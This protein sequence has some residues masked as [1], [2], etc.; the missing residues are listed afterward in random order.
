MSSPTN[1]D[2]LLST[3][4]ESTHI[5]DPPIVEALET[6]SP[7]EEEK[8]GETTEAEQLLSDG[9]ID[10]RVAMLGNVD[11]GKS[12]LISVLAH[13]ALDD[14]RGAA[15]ARVFRHKH[16]QENGRTSSISLELM[17][18]DER[19]EQVF[20]E[21][22]RV[23][24]S[25]IVSRSSKNITLIDL[26][27][28]EKY[29]KTTIFGLTGM[30]PDYCFVIVGANMGVSKMTR[31]HLGIALSLKIP[32]IVIITKIDISPENIKFETFQNLQKLLKSPAA[33]KKMP[34]VVRD[35]DDVSTCAHGLPSGR[36]VPFFEISSVTGENVE[37]LRSF[38]GMLPQRIVYDPNAPAEFVI[39]GSYQVSGIGL[40]IAGTLNKGTVQTNDHLL[41]GPDRTSQFR[42]VA[43]KSI[44]SKRTP[45]SSVTAGQSATFAIRA[46]TK[47][48][49]L[50]RVYIRKGMVLVSESGNPRAVEE[51][52]AE[53]LI[54][55]HHTTIAIGY[56]PMIHCG[57]VRQSAR[58]LS[59]DREVL[60]TGD[61]AIVRFR[62]MYRS[63]YVTEGQ[64][65]IF[66]EG[67]AKGL[68]RIISCSTFH[69]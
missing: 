20:G 14:G 59:M 37:L 38:V 53:V 10:V 42:P 15:R 18:F 61:R 48:D 51:F 62:F 39:D 16:E 35:M 58:I 64:K 44:H 27:G 55:H 21:G 9:L 17:G 65:F 33:G 68:G 69:T 7:Q 56:Q 3:Q 66:R 13:G 46:L 47:K 32:I 25:E 45:V 28:H 1:T 31:E 6:K 50:K 41:L 12:T 19:G 2:I 67:R 26:C 22:G 5:E 8:K 4:M 30:N 23:S 36:I 34:Y 54:L 11:S 40:V 60:R 24:W 29:L 63:E 57:V 43:I 52:E 49:Q